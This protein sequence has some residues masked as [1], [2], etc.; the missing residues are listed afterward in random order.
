MVR[1]AKSD[2]GLE[3]SRLLKTEYEAEEG[4]LATLR[5]LL[6]AREA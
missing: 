3:A 6:N 2:D 5:Q 4:G 1:L